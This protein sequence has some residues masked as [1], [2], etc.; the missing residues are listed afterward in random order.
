MTEREK[1]RFISGG[2][3]CAAWYYPGTGGTCVIMCGGFAVTKEPGTDRFAR[4]FQEAGLGVLA[5]DPRRL[6]ESGGTPR[7]VVRIKDELADWRAAIDFAGTLPG[8]DPDRIAL[9]GFSL[10]GGHVL[11][12]AARDA[13]VAAVIAQTPNADGAKAVRAAAKFQKPS[14]LLRLAALGVADA[15]LGLAGRPPMLVPLVAPRGTLATLSTPDAVATPEALD[16][17]GEYAD[18][19]QAVAAR[20]TFA[21]GFYRPGRAASKIRC[22][23]LVVVAEQDQ[24]ALPGPAIEVA[25]RAPGAELFRV[26]GGHY[27]PFLDS[28]DRVVE[29]EV[30][31]L[32]RHLAGD[33]SAERVAGAQS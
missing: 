23:L 6:G 21:L 27:A 22:P 16:P 15:V 4:R 13:R 29:A 5:F 33:V 32:R 10:S 8:V 7:Q 30:A 31:F 18:W 17:D 9:W 3:E 14:L 12:L 20:S 1:V 11:R 24:T 25:R 2:D 26:P 28:H 19:Q